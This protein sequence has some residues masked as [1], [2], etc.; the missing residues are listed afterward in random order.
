M[1]QCDIYILE[2]VDCGVKIPFLDGEGR[3]DICNPC[4]NL[5][6]MKTPCTYATHTKTTKFWDLDS[7][8]DNV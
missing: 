3:R 6:V 5:R 7:A 1:N 4:M 2:C 8:Y